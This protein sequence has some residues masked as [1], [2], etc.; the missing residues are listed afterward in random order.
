MIPVIPPPTLIEDAQDLDA[1]LAAFRRDGFV[2]VRVLDPAQCAD[3]IKEQVTEILLQQPWKRQ[4]EVR[5][6]ASGLLLDIERDTAAYLSALC[7]P[8]LPA[9]VLKAWEEAWPFH[10]GFGACC[11]PA[12][13]HLQTVWSLRQ[14]PRLYAIASSIMGETELW[15][16][17]NRV[18]HKLPGK[19]EDE[20]L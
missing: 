5:D 14:D 20:F 9:S 11:D 16:D 12:A 7:A 18:I 19:G 1:I 13:F 10:A 4:L 6:P 2:V 17:I 3:A 15:V 8:R